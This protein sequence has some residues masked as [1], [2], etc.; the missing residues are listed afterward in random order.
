MLKNM[1][2]IRNIILI[3]GALIVGTY[4]LMYLFQDMLIFRTRK[5]YTDTA[6]SIKEQ[7]PDSEITIKT[8]DGNRLHGWLI[9]KEPTPCPLLIYFGG[10]AE[11]VSGFISNNMNRFDHVSILSLN[12]RGYGNSDGSPSEKKLFQDAITIFDTISERED[13]KADQIIAMGRSLGTGVAVHLA[14]QRDVTAVVLVSPYDSIT[15]IAK[16]RYPFAPVS[17]L[18]KHPFN[19][20]KKAPTIEKPMLCL[21]ASEDNT[22]PPKYS[23]RLVDKWGGQT[24]TKIINHEDHNSINSH[25]EYWKTI[26]QFVNKI[27]PMEVNSDGNSQ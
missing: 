11:E 17:L 7:F 18:I 23:K 26:N 15:N 16:S 9:Q 10:N 27:F 19:S 22:I 3:S 14:S 4:L 12:Y 6:K 2:A 13:I 1:I 20:I 8:P 24:T 21:I 5:L 25:P